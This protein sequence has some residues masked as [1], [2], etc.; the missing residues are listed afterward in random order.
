[1]NSRNLQWLGGFMTGVWN[2]SPKV[3]TCEAREVDKAVALGRSWKSP[4]PQAYTA[5]ICPLPANFEPQASSF[6][7]QTPNPCFLCNHR[8]LTA[9]A[10][11]CFEVW[12]AGFGAKIDRIAIPSPTKWA[13][14]D[15]TD[16]SDAIVIVT[17]NPN[18]ATWP[19]E[20]PAFSQASQSLLLEYN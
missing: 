6:K 3:V 16:Y 18:V 17:P 9:P 13:I 4:V 10:P 15:T 19:L 8:N 5:I 1:M 12:A 7:L 2:L 11:G 20:R 14:R